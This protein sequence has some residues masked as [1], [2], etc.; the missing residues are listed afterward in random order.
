MTVRPRGIVP[1]VEGPGDKAAAPIL[2]RRVLHERLRRYDVRVLQ[3][4]SA[5]GKPRLVKRLENFL[6]YARITPECAAVLVLIDADEEC[7][8]ELGAEL[9]RRARAIG[10][11]IPIAVVCAKPE[12]ENWF[13]ASDQTFCGDVEEYRGAKEWLSRKMP[14]GLAYKETTISYS[15]PPPLISKRRLQLRGPFAGSVTLS[16]HS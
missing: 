1:I 8:R 12:Y 13:L 5:N 3:P 6:G 7:P 15:F 2:L 16:K 14:R 9:A 4:K 11:G 10:V